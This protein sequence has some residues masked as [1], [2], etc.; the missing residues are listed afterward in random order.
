MDYLKK[1]FKRDKSLSVNDKDQIASLLKTTPQ[2]LEA[3]EEV[4][5]DNILMDTSFPDNFFDVNAKQAASARGK[6]DDAADMDKLIG[7]IVKELMAQADI[8]S[9]DG[10]HEMLKCQRSVDRAGCY[11]GGNRSVSKEYAP[12]ADRL[13]Y[14]A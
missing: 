4:Y 1:L 2:A 12:A 3:F 7:R 5:R 11:Q 9:F 10:E 14:E 8:Y 13:F 6:L